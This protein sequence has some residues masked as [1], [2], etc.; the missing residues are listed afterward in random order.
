MSK[1]ISFKPC[2]EQFPSVAVPYWFCPSN[3]L[4]TLQMDHKS[5]FLLLAGMQHVDWKMLNIQRMNLLTGRMHSYSDSETIF[6]HLMFDCLGVDSHLCSTD[7]SL[8]VLNVLTGILIS[9]N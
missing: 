4:N 8:K 5:C 3:D 2:H 7:L 9:N 1:R 6:C